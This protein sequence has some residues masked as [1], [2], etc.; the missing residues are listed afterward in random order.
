MLGPSLQPVPDAAHGVDQFAIGRRVDL[1]AEI[2]DV[3]VND[4][5]HFVGRQIPDVLKDLRARD[6]AAGVAHE[7]FKEC[8]FLGSEHNLPTCTHNRMI[9]ATQ[10]EVVDL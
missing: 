3:D 10:L 1:S 9:H 2:V 6:M 7:V 4:V 8:K 5:G